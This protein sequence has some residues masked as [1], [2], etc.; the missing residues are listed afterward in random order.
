MVNRIF[1]LLIVSQ[2][3]LVFFGFIG[4]WTKLMNTGYE[5]YGY[6]DYEAAIIVF[7]EASLN[8]PNNPIVHYNLGTA[9]YKQGKYKQAAYAF[10]TTLLKTNIHNKADVYYNLGNAQFQMH[11]LSAAVAS[12]KSSLKLNPR[13]IDAKHN[14]NLALKLLAEEKQNITPQ[15][16]EQKSKQDSPKREPKD[17]SKSETDRLL[18]LL[19]MNES[20]RRKKILKQQLKTGIWRDKDW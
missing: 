12:Y 20:R 13:D 8:K 14:L 3:I 6:Q 7:H 16:E 9:Y 18:E 2:F 17:L 11:D 19:S 10:Q 5:A 1:I 15:Q 4:H